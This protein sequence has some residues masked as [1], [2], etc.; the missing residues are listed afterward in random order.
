MLAGRTI[1]CDIHAQCA[2]AEGV[3]VAAGHGGGAHYEYETVIPRKW[4]APEWINHDQ[5]VFQ[6]M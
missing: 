1:D 5:Y 6:V 4:G 2:P 3:A